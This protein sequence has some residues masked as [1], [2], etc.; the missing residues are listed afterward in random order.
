MFSFLWSSYV[1]Q[2]KLVNPTE[3]RL[4][5][6]ITQ[7]KWRLEEGEG[8]AI[9]EIGVEDNGLLMGLSKTDL[10]ASMESLETMALRLAYKF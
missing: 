2:L 7:M 4:E 5:H 6:L 9:Y 1:L 8:E 3:S 10:D